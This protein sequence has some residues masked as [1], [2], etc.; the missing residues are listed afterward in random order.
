M[1]TNWSKNDENIVK[2][3]IVNNPHNI[4]HSLIEA[5]KKI[6][7]SFQATHFRY[8]SKIR[9]EKELFDLVSSETHGRIN[10]KNIPVK[11]SYLKGVYIVELNKVFTLKDNTIDSLPKECQQYSFKIVDIK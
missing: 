5:S 1:R 9:Y 2:E 6:G 4:K 11:S 7:R 10:T 8:Y 3:C